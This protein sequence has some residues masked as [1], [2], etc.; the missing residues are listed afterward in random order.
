MENP[1]S[2]PPAPQKPSRAG[3]W[4][5]AALVLAVIAGG[6]G[7]WL[8]GDSQTSEEE[9]AA[10]AELSN[11]G[12][13]PAMDAER[14]H[15][16][17]INLSTLRSPESLGR[18]LELLADL[19]YLRSLNVDST[20]FSDEHAAAVGRLDS[21]E[22]L[23]LNNTP[24]SDSALEKLAGLSELSTLHLVGTAVTDAGLPA[25]AR[26][27]SVEIL[28]L[29]ATKVTKNLAPLAEMPNL[30]HLLLQNLT[31]DAAALAAIADFPA[32]TRLTL[33]ESTY[34]AEALTELKQ[35]KSGLAIDE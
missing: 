33:R 9:L 30:K 35:K 32:I 13:L 16:N 23:V 7:W 8:L 10:K 17:S 28:D 11:L 29:S 26:I 2:E 19:P 6:L 12:A 34:P 5:A 1:A 3:L 31:L 25:L 18:A 24:I 21:L 27:R 4:I 14:I 15:V 20:Q 22:S